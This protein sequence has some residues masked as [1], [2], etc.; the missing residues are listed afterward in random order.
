MLAYVDRGTPQTVVV[1]SGSGTQDLGFVLKSAHETFGTTARLQKDALNGS[2]STPTWR[3]TGESS[4]H[5]HL[6]CPFDGLPKARLLQTSGR[7]SGGAEESHG[8]RQA[9]SSASFRGGKPE[10][11]R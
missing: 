2:N 7:N 1:R 4:S 3:P 11:V 5:H 9:I 6:F 8:R 10:G